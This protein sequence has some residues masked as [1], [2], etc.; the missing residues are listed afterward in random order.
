MMSP[1]RILALMFLAGMLMFRGAVA[2][3]IEK[4][5]VSIAVGGK[6]ALYY[7]PLSLAEHLGYF[8]DEGLEV[9]INDFQGGSKSL[10]A[11]IG[12]SADVVAG[13]FDHNI[14]M[15][16]LAQKMTAFVLIAM[17]P[18][19]SVGVVKSKAAG[20]RSPLGLKG[21]RV[22]VTAPGSGTHMIINHLLASAGLTPDDIVPVA[23]GTGAMAIAAV[24]S[25][26][27]DAI[28][29][30]EPAMT[31]LESQGLV[32]IVHETVT[33]KGTFNVFGGS[34]P[35]GTLYAK[36]SF[37][38]KYPGTVQAL[39]NAMVRAL[40]WLSKATA[41]DVVAVVPREYL[42]GDPALYLAALKRLKPTYSKDGLIPKKGVDQVYKVLVSTNQ[43]V[44]RAPVL[45]L[46][47]TFDNSFVQRALIRYR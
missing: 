3:E 31:L 36:Q 1:R 5:E 9:E 34:I 47:Q 24:H 15:Q 27:I 25:G 19:V 23:V 33:D 43:A 7:L 32:T 12:G 18:G 6:A 40:V 30:V 38:Q 2:F 17:N 16:T 13:A 28:C 45:F 42:L 10:Q 4:R 29:N 39:T 21:M 35:A 44:R 22:G 26:E 14:V 41:E 20:Y 46:Q 11:M 37:I 8:K